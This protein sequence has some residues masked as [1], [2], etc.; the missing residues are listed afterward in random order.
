VV[1]GA[2]QAGLARL[3]K[4]SGREMARNA[5]LLAAVESLREHQEVART[6]RLCMWEYGDVQSDDEDD[7]RGRPPPRR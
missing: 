4:R 6:Q 3:E 2:A 1:L 7:M 5:A